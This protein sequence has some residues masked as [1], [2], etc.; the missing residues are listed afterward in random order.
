MGEIGIERQN[1]KGDLHNM[2]IENLLERYMDPLLQGRRGDC[3]ELVL[4]ALESGVHPRSLYSGLIW[5]AMQRVEQLYREDRINRASEHMAVRINRT[6]ADHLQT[7]LPRKPTLER[8]IIVTCAHDEPEEFSA[9]MVA[10]LFEADGWDVYFLGGGVPRDEVG[11]LVGKIQPHLLLIFGSKP[12]DAPLVRE[13][14]DYVREMNACPE[15]NI[16]I[17]GGVFNRADGL[18]KEV[19]ADLF[20]ETAIEALDMASAA[21]PRP[22]E[23]KDPSAPKKRR[24]RRR[25][26]LLAQYEEGHV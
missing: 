14:I 17:S 2:A 5:P 23:E 15:M 24:R 9:Q 8:K 20:A 19:K 25:P 3:R 16:M 22:P 4:S 11:E 6:V 10:D 12:T 21:Q 7:R 13:M 26:P 1:A 18:W